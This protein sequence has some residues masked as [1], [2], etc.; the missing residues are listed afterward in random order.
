MY[1]SFDVGDRLFAEKI[2]YKYIRYVLLFELPSVSCAAP[3]PIILSDATCFI[4]GCKSRATKA[5]SP[6]SQTSTKRVC[7]RAGK[8]LLAVKLFS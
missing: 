3:P 4:I 8:S 7:S 6:Y 2:S 1:P 5:M